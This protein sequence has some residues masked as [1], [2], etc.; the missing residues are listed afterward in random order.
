MIKK[1]I[2]KELKEKY[3][4]YSSWMLWMESNKNPTDN[5][6]NL[7]I[8]KDEEKLLKEL[9]TEYVFIAFNA[10]N[11]DSYDP[12]KNAWSNFHSKDKRAKDYRLRKY[13]NNSKYRGSYLT[14]IYKGI[15]ITDMSEAIKYIEENPKYQEE[16]FKDLKNELEL[17][18]KN[19]NGKKPKIFVFGAQAYKHINKA[20]LDGY[21]IKQIYHFS[22]RGSETKLKE[23]WDK[24]KK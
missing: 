6:G 3:A 16:R 7:D 2:Y 21:E 8:F 14:D 12:R 13:F 24:I 22:F 20:N 23:N 4:E 9:N 15:S 19:N 5:V 18:T 10:A 17:L 1:E 11:Q